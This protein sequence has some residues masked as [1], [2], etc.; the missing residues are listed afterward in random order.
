MSVISLYYVVI[1]KNG[2]HL[3]VVSG[4]YFTEDSAKNA[5]DTAEPP[6]GACYL[7]IA[8]V[9]HESVSLYGY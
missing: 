9:E 2:M 5:K 1:A 3:E 8:I 6:G 7:D 4:P